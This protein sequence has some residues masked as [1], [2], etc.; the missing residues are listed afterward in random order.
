M[1]QEQA[2]R[3]EAEDSADRPAHDSRTQVI[4][5]GPV[6]PNAADMPSAGDRLEESFPAIQVERMPLFE[7]LDLMS[8]LGGIPISLGPEALR[9]AAIPADVPVSVD[10]EGQT[11]G[12]ALNRAIGPLHLRCK[13]EG[14]QVR[15]VR[16][17]ARK[18]REIN[19]PVD[20]LIT[21]ETSFQQ[22]AEWVRRMVAPGSW[23]SDGGEGT[24]RIEEGEKKIFHIRQSQR[25]QYQILCFLERLRLARKLDLRSRYPAGRLSIVPACQ[26]VAG[27]LSGPATFTFL[28]DTPLTEIFAYWQQQLG[29]PLL[30]DWPALLDQQLGP[31]TLIACSVIEQPWHEAID[32]VLEP[33][34][35]AWRALD[36][37]TLQITTASLVRTDPQLEIYP[38]TSYRGRTAGQPMGEAEL[39]RLRRLVERHHGASTARAESAVIL[40]PVS[41][42]LLVRQPASVQRRIVEWLDE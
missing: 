1:G 40:D 31:Q 33:L 18:Q 2:D 14:P 6:G 29:L 20:D 28:R 41:K 8:G 24:L 16:P 35:L 11:L 25:I 39:D 38:L 19:Y 5:R 9:M 26:S 12:E 22:L 13:A 30:V 10:V 32:R 7:L 15:I 3:L 27:P 42:A 23:Q 36:G 17:D 37:N 4:R 21:P 34:G